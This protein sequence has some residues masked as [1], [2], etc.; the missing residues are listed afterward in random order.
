M[1]G[2]VITKGICVRVPIR[3]LR[4]LL[5]WFGSGLFWIGL[6]VFYKLGQPC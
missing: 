3:G 6:I 1:S 5:F 2:C 4:C